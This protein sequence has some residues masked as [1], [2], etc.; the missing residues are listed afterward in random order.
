MFA[1]GVDAFFWAANIAIQHSD[2]A[3]LRPNSNFLG[4]IAMLNS[5]RYLIVTEKSHF[6]AMWAKL[7]QNGG[8]ISGFLNSIA[9]HS[10]CPSSHYERRYIL[11]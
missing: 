2:V 1:V 4:P 7:G 10:D 11:D 8:L 6:F 5:D 3:M 9:T